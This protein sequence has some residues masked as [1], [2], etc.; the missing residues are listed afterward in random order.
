[1]ALTGCGDATNEENGGGAAS[2]ELRKLPGGGWAPTPGAGGDRAEAQSA[3]AG[4]SAAS[5]LLYPG[6]RIRYEAA[7][8]LPDLRG[9]AAAYEAKAEIDRDDAERLASAFG[10]KGSPKRADD[11][12]WHVQDGTRSA[13]ISTH[14]LGDWSVSE[15]PT[16]TPA[17]GSVSSCPGAP[18]G[19]E[20]ACDSGSKPLPG[21]E[22]EIPPDLPSPA[23]AEKRARA[24][25]DEAGVEIAD[26]AKATVS[27]P[28]SEGITVT[29]EIEVDGTPAPGMGQNVT[30][31]SGG[32]VK[33]ASGTLATF[34]D[35]GDYPLVGTEAGIERM[36]Q[37]YGAAGEVTILG[38]PEAVPDGVE[39]QEQVQVI[40]GVRL[41]LMPAFPMCPGQ[42]MY[43]VPAYQFTLRGGEPGPVFNA[44]AEEHL[45]DSGAADRRAP[46]AEIDPCQGQRG[47]GSEPG[48]KP[49]DAV[50]FPPAEPQSSR[51][52]EPAPDRPPAKP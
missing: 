42:P 31:G 25:L 49:D 12:S 22:P 9:P 38:G 35:I 44:V 18:P 46:Q 6:F 23:A 36:Q 39:P 7:P 30:L 40:E 3:P 17:S 2:G 5:S 48:V 24:L 51:P 52:A 11:A 16:A 26:G 37:A 27:D 10:V 19:A 28:T 14:T 4:D 13:Y 15:A 29:F 32:V 43:L 21:A 45:V 47:G 34:D 20:I 1:M 8:G 50:S 41:V 33:F